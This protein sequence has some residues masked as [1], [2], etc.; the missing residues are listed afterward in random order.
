MSGGGNEQTVRTEADR[1]LR[2]EGLDLYGNVQNYFADNPMQAYGGPAVAGVTGL[3]RQAQQGAQGL[4][5]QQAQMVTPQNV[6]TGSLLDGPGIGAY[7]NP[8]TDAVVNQSLM[9]I[10]RSRQLM[11]VGNASAAT[12]AG[13]FGGSRQGVVEAETNRAA[14]DQMARTSAQLRSQGFDTAAGLY[15]QD[16]N[17]G[18]QAGLANQGAGL[19]AGLA[20]QGAG[21]QANQQQLQAA[22]MLGGFGMQQQMTDQMG[23]DAQRRQFL[24]QQNAPLQQYALQQGFLSGIPGN[25]SQISDPGSNPGSGAL[26]GAMSGAAMGSRFG[27]LGAGIG[28]VG[29]GLLGLFG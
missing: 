19:A 2:Q 10:D 26:G 3:Q 28:A 29:G 8:Y 21:L 13:A 24:E 14:L 1:R 7:Q 17:R 5:G 12:Q 9:D 11:Q 27:P 18:M 6:Q 15:G 22:G 4:M 20:N 16:L 25:T 23:L